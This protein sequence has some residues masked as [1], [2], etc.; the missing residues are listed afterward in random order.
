MVQLDIAKSS[1]HAKGKHNRIEPLIK[2]HWN[3][4]YDELVQRELDADCKHKMQTLQQQKE[5]EQ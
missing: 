5:A 1:V 3:M 4:E 2:Q